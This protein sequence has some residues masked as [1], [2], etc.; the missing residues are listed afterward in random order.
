MDPE[1]GCPADYA[2]LFEHY[3][4]LMLKVVASAGIEY[5]DVPDVA[6]DI[7]AR[8]IEKDGIAYY[9]PDKVH[10]V[11]ENPNIPGARFRKAKFAA[12]LRGFTSTYVLQYRD[13]QI[14]RHRREP[15]RNEMPVY[16]KEGELRTWIEAHHESAS[17]DNL[18]DVEVSLQIVRALKRAR[19]I[20]IAEKDTP[21][22]DYGRLVDVCLAHGVLEGKVTRKM[23]VA[24]LG[25]SASTATHMLSDLRTTL[26]DLLQVVA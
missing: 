15:W 3:Y 6:M 10:D 5:R 25:V 19:Q 17:Y 2:E 4:P 14:I 23:V 21:T 13:K 11:G 20:L 8:F 26:K 7:L 9:D 1:T 24:E 12:M 22:R 18:A 16:S